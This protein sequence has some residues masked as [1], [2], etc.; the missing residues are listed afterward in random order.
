MNYKWRSNASMLRGRRL[1]LRDRTS[2]RRFHSTRTSAVERPTKTSSLMFF[3]SPGTLHF[4]WTYSADIGAKQKQH[5]LNLSA[6][7]MHN[8]RYSS[9]LGATWLAITFCFA[10]S[11]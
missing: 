7:E 11:I 6:H 4:N 1:V 10:T 2:F 8:G 9:R 5:G 3:S